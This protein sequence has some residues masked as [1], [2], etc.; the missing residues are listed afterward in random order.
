MSYVIGFNKII[1]EK[2]SNVYVFGLCE[3]GLM[4]QALMVQ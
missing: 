4:N 3:V 1:F 2:K